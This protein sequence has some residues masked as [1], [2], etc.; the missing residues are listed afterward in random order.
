MAS[1]LCWHSHRPH[2]RGLTFN[3]TM[4]A[5]NAIQRWYRGPICGYACSHVGLGLWLK[6]LRASSSHIPQG[7]TRLRIPAQNM[8]TRERRVRCSAPGIVDLRRQS[9]S[10]CEYSVVPDQKASQILYHSYPCHHS[11]IF[12]TP[13]G[14]DSKTMR[15][16]HLFSVITVA[17]SAPTTPRK[18]AS[19]LLQQV[20]APPHSWADQPPDH[21]STHLEPAPNSVGVLFTA[22]EQEDIIH[23]W[24]PLGQKLYTRT[25]PLLSPP[26]PSH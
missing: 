18:S 20:V 25:S 26:E 4:L 15:L 11:L 6:K 14:R 22:A 5:L 2:K 17:S 9:L 3:L 21:H 10:Y 12:P 23:L 16:S 8:F 1:Y 7:K 13:K 24:L 19:D